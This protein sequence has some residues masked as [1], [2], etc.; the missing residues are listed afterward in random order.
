MHGVQA[1]ERPVVQLPPDAQQALQSTS[2]WWTH[3]VGAVLS[4]YMLLE[5]G[6]L[7]A[8]LASHGSNHLR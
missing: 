1:L 4:T 6:Q 2:S 3:Q 5:Q 8:D 7:E